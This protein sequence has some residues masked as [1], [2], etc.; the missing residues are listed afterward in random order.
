MTRGMHFDKASHSHWAINTT[1]RC[2]DR[3]VYCF[4]G[5]RKGLHDIGPEQTQ[6]LLRKAASEVPWLFSWAPSPRSTRTCR[7]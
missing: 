7:G 3:R 1:T 4:E 6:Q 5:K 2:Q